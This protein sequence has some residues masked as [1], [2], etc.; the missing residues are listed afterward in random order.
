MM[1]N[2]Y[3]TLLLVLRP[4][5][6]GDILKVM[7]QES[8]VES[9]SP[10]FHFWTFPPYVKR[11]LT[12][13]RY[14]VLRESM[15]ITANSQEWTEWCSAEIFGTSAPIAQL[16]GKHTATSLAVCCPGPQGTILPQG[17][18]PSWGWLTTND[19]LMQRYRGLVPSHQFGITLR[20][21]L[22]SRTPCEISWGCSCR[23]IVC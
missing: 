20:G 4:D 6:L 5:N 3:W 12:K 19:R 11:K 1:K 17:Y 13:E 21:H 23:H 16:L 15:N 7:Q 2:C 18:T 10:D 22:S 8:V 14:K 9:M